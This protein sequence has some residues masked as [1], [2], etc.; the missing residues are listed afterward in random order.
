MT[1]EAWKTKLDAYLDGELSAE[2]MRVFDVHVHGCPSC[3]P[4]ALSR[5]Q[6]KRSIQTAGKRFVPSEDFRKRMQKGIAAKPERRT[7]GSS[8]VMAVALMAVLAVIGLTVS[9]QG[10]RAQTGQ[11]FSEVA[12]MHVATLAST[13]P[14]DVV[15]SDRHTVKPWFQGKIPF[16]FTLPELQNSEFSLLGGRVTYMQQTPGAHLIYEVRKHRISVFIF[17]ESSLREKL[18]AGSTADKELSFNIES[19]TQDG[20]RYFVIGDAGASEINGLAKLFKSSS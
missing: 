13:S 19:W 20:L 1:C 5:V 6:M 10:Q 7:F 2:E 3:A 12:D 11:T 4:D 18:A 16:T 15:S 9:E 14:F 8:W 17:P